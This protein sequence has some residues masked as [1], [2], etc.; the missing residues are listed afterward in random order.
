[1]SGEWCPLPFEEKK[2]SPHLNPLPSGE[3]EGMRGK[4]NQLTS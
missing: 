4:I 1:V 3:R 2:V